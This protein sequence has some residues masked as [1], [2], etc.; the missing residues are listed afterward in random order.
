MLS[1]S[2]PNTAAPT[3][4]LLTRV[5]SIDV[6]RALTTVLM[7]FVNDLWS[8]TAI[9]AWLEH[10]PG[11]VDGIG[12]ADVVF[13][14]FLFIVG[15]S[16]PFAI[17][18][19]RSKGDSDGQI[20]MHILSRTL[21]LLVMGLW[22]V[23]GEYINEAATGMK[24][25]VWNILAC[26]AF[27]LI[28]NSY[29]KSV[30]R[31][32]LIGLKIVG[33][34]VL[35]TLAV[36]YRGG[37]P[38]GRFQPHWWGILGLIGW[39]YLAGALATLIARNR[40]AVLAL[41]WVG[42]CALSMIAKANLLPPVVRL[43]PDAIS[44][45]TLAGLTLGGALTAS[46]FRYCVE[47]GRT[48][49]MTIGFVIASLVLIGLSIYTRP[50]W[51]L[52]KL[53]ATPAWLFLCSAFTLLAFTALHWLVDVGGNGHWFRVIKPAGTDTLLCYLMPYFAYA[54]VVLA[55]LHLPLALLAGSVGLLKSLLFALLCVWGTGR[56]NRLG[57]RLKL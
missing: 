45:G 43:I 10:V 41:I 49:L 20:A 21:A 51:G 24:R 11:G 55:H 52:A 37:E 8:L 39:S 38:L 50:I 30:A 9:P 19:R 12:L 1:T 16:A 22:L 44:G 35:L 26:G 7:I 48:R 40:I 29:P 36:V 18:H 4:R 15:L 13:P 28:W 31:P 5:D 57:V 6:L 17:Q 27:I 25:V 32:L 3:H 2:V 34:L 54:I 56:I 42:F 46:V 33:W 23:N 53:G 47:R 14:A